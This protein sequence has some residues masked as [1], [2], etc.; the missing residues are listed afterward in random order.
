MADQVLW[1][2][3]L[4]CRRATATSIV[5]VV[6]V[7]RASRHLPVRTGQA[8]NDRCGPDNPEV[9]DLTATRRQCAGQPKPSISVC[10]R[11]VPSSAAVADHDRG[12]RPERLG[13]F[14][15]ESG[16]QA[17]GLFVPGGQKAFNGYCNSARHRLDRDS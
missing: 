3:A 13:R 1:R 10:V 8:S 14:M 15:P 6:V 16:P 2:A 9:P 4:L 17:A 12:E 5:F 11:G 7:I